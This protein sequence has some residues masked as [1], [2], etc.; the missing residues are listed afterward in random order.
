MPYTLVKALLWLVLAF[1]LGLTIGWLL[2][3]VAAGRQRK[4]A[5]GRSDDTAELERLRGRVANLETELEAARAQI[6]TPAIGDDP[7][8]P[9]EAV[10]TRPDLAAAAAELGRTIELDD[11]TVIE[12]IGASIEELCHGIGIRTWYDLS[13]T[14]VSLLRTMLNDAGARFKMHDPGTWPRQAELLTYGKWAEF[15][16]LSD[17]L[18]EGVTS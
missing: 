9:S 1:G 3:S 7:P 6:S 11:L 14:E 8:Q 2:R 18:R 5:R 17:A 4:R 15:R 10:A 12:G 16:E 13:T